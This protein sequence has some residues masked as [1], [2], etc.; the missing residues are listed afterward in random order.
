MP[1]DDALAVDVAVNIYAAVVMAVAVVALFRP[2]RG[3]GH[4][5]E[6]GHSRGLGHCSV[7]RRARVRAHA[8]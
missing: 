3:R 2:G 1:I 4:G 8:Y 6:G 5:G 7:P